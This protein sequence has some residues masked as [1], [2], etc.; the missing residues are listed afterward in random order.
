MPSG[1]ETV[2][3]KTYSSRKTIQIAAA[4][5]MVV[6]ALLTRPIFRP[7]LLA[8]ISGLKMDRF[9][10]ASL[11]PWMAFSLYWEIAAKNSA[12]IVKSE[13][14]ASRLVHV[15]LTN[16]ALLL[17]IAPIRPLSQRLLPDA[18][19]V[20][21]LGL[22][23]ECA[24]LAL[25]IWARRVLGRNWSG[26]ITIKENHELVRT[27]PYATVR[28]PIYTALLAMY[29]G[30]AIVFGQMHALIGLVIGM[31]AYLRKTR[32]EEVNLVNAFGQR[33]DDYRKETWAIV[34]GIY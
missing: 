29:V 26:E 3:R 19:T 34:P 23:L 21:L 15:V 22:G 6:G 31:I 24:G 9:A 28:H 20:K 1:S 7:W 5:G 25:A 4:V 32:M 33:Y 30:T 14:K 27:G 13:S 12:P 11:A 10:L 2:P 17:I 18:V 16:V 8:H